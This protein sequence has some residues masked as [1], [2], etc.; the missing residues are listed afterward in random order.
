MRNMN[1]RKA[2]KLTGVLFTATLLILAACTN[3]KLAP[4]TG[5]S[6]PLPVKDSGTLRTAE[7]FDQDK[8]KDKLTVRYFYMDAAEA[9]GDCVLIQTPDGKTMMIDSGLPEVGEQVVNYLNKLNVQTIDVALNTHPHSDHIGGFATVIKQ[10]D[11]KKFY[12]ENLPYPDSNAYMNVINALQEKNIKPEYLEEGSSFELGSDLKVTVL[13]PKKGVLPQA[14]KNYDYA[15]LN[16]YSMVVKVTY[17]NTS[18][19]FTADIYKDREFELV[20]AKADLNAN[21]THVPHHGNATS[22]S[23][24]FIEAV[25]P[26]YAVMSSNIFQTPEIM[27]RYQKNNVTVYSTGLHG[28]VLITSDGE[29]LN[30]ITEKDWQ[31]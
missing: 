25:S 31:P 29:K 10:K 1:W 22:S 6:T 7:I 27:K 13:S 15:T 4:V 23:N 2:V 26:Q 28:N 5:T 11:V 24:S 18:F 9:S 3:A 12:M 20:E 17:K 14:V 21:F 19:L 30:A 8:Y 16:Y